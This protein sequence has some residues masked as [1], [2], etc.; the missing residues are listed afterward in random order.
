MVER[1]ALLELQVTVDDL[2]PVVRHPVRE[3]IAT[4]GIDGLDAS[5]DSSGDILVDCASSDR[6][7]RRRGIH[8]ALPPQSKLVQQCFKPIRI[9][10]EREL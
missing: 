1:D 6:D 4:V 3:G 8:I 5:D 2:E 10:R 9:P 7:A